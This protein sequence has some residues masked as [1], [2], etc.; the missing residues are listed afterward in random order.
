M[1]LR[2]R[3]IG[4]KA[5]QKWPNMTK[6]GIFTFFAGFKKLPK[7]LLLSFSTKITE[8]KLEIR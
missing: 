7:N 2:H 5:F 6:T 8:K 3:N 1:W 4:K